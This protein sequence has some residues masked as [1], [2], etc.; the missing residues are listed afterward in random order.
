MKFYQFGRIWKKRHIKLLTYTIQPQRQSATEKENN[1][2][3]SKKACGVR[4]LMN[5]TTTIQ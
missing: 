5:K 4:V 1:I 2:Q 3:A